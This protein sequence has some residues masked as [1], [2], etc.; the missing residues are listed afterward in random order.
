MDVRE[1]VEVECKYANYLKKQNREIAAFRQG[2]AMPLPVD[3]DYK[4]SLPMISNE[5]AE[6]LSANRPASVHA[7]SRIPGSS[8][9]SCPN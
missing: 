1:H 6:I 3:V 5:E 9:E 2:D 4:E 8:A 7:A